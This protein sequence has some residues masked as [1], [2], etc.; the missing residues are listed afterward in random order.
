MKANYFKAIFLTLSMTTITTNNVLAM[1]ASALSCTQEINQAKEDKE[2]EKESNDDSD[3]I[4]EKDNAPL[5]TVN[6]TGKFA[7]FTINTGNLQNDQPVQITVSNG[8][9]VTPTS[10][11][12]N[13]KNATITVKLI[14]TK[15][16]TKGIIVLRS[17]DSR[18]YIRLQGIGTPLPVKE[19]AKSPVYKGGKDETFENTKFKPTDKGYTVE[20][21]VK[22]NEE[23]DEFHPYM[24]DKDGYSLKGFVASTAMGVYNSTSQ[25]GFSNPLTKI[26]GGLGKFYNN[27]NRMHT[28]RYAIT[29]DKRAFIYRDGFPIDTIRLADYGNQ[30]D[31]AIANGEAKE[32]LLKNPGFEGEYDY[33]DEG[34]LVK[35]IEG[36]NIAILDKWNNEQFILSQEIDN[37]QDFNNHIFRIKPYKWAGGWGNGN[38]N[39]T[40][41]V[42]PNETYTLSAL[43]KGGLDKKKGAL[44]AKIIIQEVE[45]REKKVE[46]EIASDTWETYSLDFTTSPTCKQIRVIFQIQAGKWGA[47]ITPLD[48]DN[49]K[50]TGTSRTYAPKIGFENN[51]TEIEYFTYDLSGAYAPEQPEIIINIT[52]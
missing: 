10:I 17:G 13:I 38:I 27:D 16:V 20:F 41:D 45:D 32:N 9:S 7:T 4:N 29:P 8:F 43:A 47:N 21:K 51:N 25:K 44:T 52:E 35:A 31:L 26:E 23:G 2:K 37:E 24:V 42:A 34:K 39:Q 46:T 15:K 48:V 33:M 22:I 14:S 18:S 28:Y 3:V 19:I 1:S 6:G 30:A 36:W 11:P 12:A 49:V 50:L 40:I 5:L